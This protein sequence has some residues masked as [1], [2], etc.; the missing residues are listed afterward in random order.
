[1]GVVLSLLVLKTGVG[2]TR[3]FSQV[4]QVIVKKKMY[5]YIYVHGV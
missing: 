1:M 5:E 3:R 2:F 4:A